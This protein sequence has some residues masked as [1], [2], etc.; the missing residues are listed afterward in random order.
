MEG[1]GDAGVLEVVEGFPVELGIAVGGCQGL[2]APR[3]EVG[4]VVA[5]YDYFVLEVEGVEPVDL[6]LDFGGG[7]G[8]GEVSGVDEEVAGRDV[9]GLQA[10]SVR[11]ADDADRWRAGCWEY[12][13]AAEGEVHESNE[14][15]DGLG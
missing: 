12:P 5:G 15:F 7:A 1:E 14:G 11:Y 6:G 8:I 2:A 13:E 3:V 9:I 10:V 4:V